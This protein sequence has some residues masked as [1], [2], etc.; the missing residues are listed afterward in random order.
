V[1]I[2]STPAAIAPL[3]FITLTPQQCELLEDLFFKKLKCEKHAKQ[4]ITESIALRQSTKAKKRADKLTT[5]REHLC[6]ERTPVTPPTDSSPS[7]EPTIA[8][9]SSMIIDNTDAPASPQDA[10]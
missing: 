5:Q 2:T 1:C 7:V 9:S 8:S 3:Q 10:N 6:Q 4:C